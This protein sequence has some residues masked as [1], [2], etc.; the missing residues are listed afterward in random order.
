MDSWNE[1]GLGGKGALTN[2]GWLPTKVHENVEKKE[3][4]MHKAAAEEKKY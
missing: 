3:E 4:T 1:N 2:R